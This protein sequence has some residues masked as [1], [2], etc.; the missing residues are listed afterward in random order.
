M[1][2]PALRVRRWEWWSLSTGFPTDPTRR[3][4]AD[5]FGA[6]AAPDGASGARGGGGTSAEL[7]E[8]VYEHLRALAASRLAREA[9]GQTI[10]PTALVHEVYLR[11]SKGARRGAD[12]RAMDDTADKAGPATALRWNDHN[13]FISAAA[14]A[15]RRILVE[16]ARDRQAVKRGG[17]GRGPSDEETAGLP[18]GAKAVHLEFDEFERTGTLGVD[19]LD[20]IAIDEALAALQAHDPDLAQLVELR[21]FAGLSVAETA[22]ALGVS[23]RTINRDWQVA[24]MWMQRWLGEDRAGPGVGGG[25]GGR[26][27]EDG[28]GRP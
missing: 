28:G 6:G 3:L 21:C 5:S 16:R 10:Q 7:I 13:H 27:T 2:S 24:R 15:M 14:L 12:V 25:G 4:D 1:L 20:W 11:L 19:A 9:P 23:E 26:V 8:V 22:A 18:R 17:G